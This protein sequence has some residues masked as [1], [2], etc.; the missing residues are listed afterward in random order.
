MHGKPSISEIG[1]GWEILGI[2]KLPREQTPRDQNVT[3]EGLYGEK[4]RQFG[5]GKGES[6]YESSEG[7]VAQGY[8]KKRRQGEKR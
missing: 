8:I 1:A 7:R 5:T 4:S 2:P 3:K 6:I